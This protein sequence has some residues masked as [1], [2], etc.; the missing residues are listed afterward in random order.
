MEVNWLHILL[1]FI[2]GYTL[3]GMMKPQSDK[4][5]EGMGG[6]EKN[7]AGEKGSGDS[8]SPVFTD[9]CGEPEKCLPDNTCFGG[10]CKSTPDC[11]SSH[12]SKVWDPT[13]LQKDSGDGVGGLSSYKCI[14][15]YTNA[16]VF[17]GNC[18]KPPYGDGASRPAGEA[19]HNWNAYSAACENK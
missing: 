16:V 1:A 17:N 13:C 6:C 12:A 3:A 9:T 19:A 8:V 15:K 7:K 11:S 14:K 4:I 2:A 5:V 18:A 10:R